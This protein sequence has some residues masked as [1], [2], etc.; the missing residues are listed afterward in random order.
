MTAVITINGY[1]HVKT[2]AVRPLLPLAL[3]ARSEEDV[4]LV[5]RSMAGVTTFRAVFLFL[6]CTTDMVT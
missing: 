5:D 2:D 1:V 3:A 4:L 6:L